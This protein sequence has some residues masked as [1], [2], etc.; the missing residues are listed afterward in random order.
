MQRFS[1]YQY[2]STRLLA[3]AFGNLVHYATGNSTRHTSQRSLREKIVAL[4]LSLF[5][6]FWWL[7]FV[8][9][10][11]RRTGFDSTLLLAAA[12]LARATPFHCERQLTHVFHR[13]RGHCLLIP[14]YV[15]HRQFA[16][17]YFIC[18]LRD[19]RHHLDACS[20]RVLEKICQCQRQFR[21]FRDDERHE[22]LL[23]K[24]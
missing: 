24:M 22:L 6:S 5:L 23:S 18:R 1:K 8:E 2:F 7:F 14:V 15:L 12:F 10:S 11:P 17:G 16:H 9:R 21:E 13:S 4:S 20:F 19:M 3:S